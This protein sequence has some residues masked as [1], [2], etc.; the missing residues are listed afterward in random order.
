[1]FQSRLLHVEVRWRL[2][3]EPAAGDPRDGILLE[4]VRGDHPWTSKWIEL[5]DDGL[6]PPWK[7]GG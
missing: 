2:E 1:M 4:H 6:G 7:K 5:G 3:K